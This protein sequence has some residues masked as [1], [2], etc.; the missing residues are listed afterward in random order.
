M[1]LYPLSRC[2]EENSE[3]LQWAESSGDLEQRGDVSPFP[4]DVQGG[5]PI[6]AQLGHIPTSREIQ[7]PAK[8]LDSGCNL[9]ENSCTRK[10]TVTE[11]DSQSSLIHLLKKRKE[12]QEMEKT[13]AE[14]DKVRK[15]GSYDKQQREREKKMKKDGELLRAKMELETLRQEHQ[16]LCKKVQKSSIS[17]KYLEDVVKVSQV[18]L[19][20]SKTDD[21]GLGEGL[22]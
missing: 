13:L 11:E 19:N 20:I 2:T 14:K 18:G 6:L 22:R 10:L 15:M 4:Q 17:K 7:H 3:M 1:K 9:K 12:A 5:T 16:K 8:E 21:D